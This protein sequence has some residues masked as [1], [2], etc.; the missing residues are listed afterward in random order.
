VSQDL[1]G[2]EDVPVRDTRLDRV[3][4]VSPLDHADGIKHAATEAYRDV[5]LRCESNLARAR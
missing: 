5:R 3:R 4:Q 2:N 1:D